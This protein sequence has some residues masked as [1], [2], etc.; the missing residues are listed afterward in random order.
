MVWAESNFEVNFN[1]SLLAA[2]QQTFDFDILGVSGD[3]SCFW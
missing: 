3:E 2:D 1:L